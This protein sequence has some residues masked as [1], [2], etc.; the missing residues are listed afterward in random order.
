[1]ALP[2]PASDKYGTLEEMDDK[3]PKTRQQVENLIRLIKRGN[4]A[5]LSQARNELGITRAEFAYNY[6]IPEQ[7]LAKWESGAEQPSDKD[8]IRWKLKLSNLVDAAI[9]G[10]LGTEDPNTPS[11]GN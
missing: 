11:S 1:M 4:S 3:Q 6:G 10:L 5:S 7:Q 2:C 8:Y 9:A